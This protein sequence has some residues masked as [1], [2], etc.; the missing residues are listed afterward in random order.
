MREGDTVDSVFESRS[1]LHRVV[2]TAESPQVE[3]VWGVSMI[4]TLLT[5]FRQ[6]HLRAWTEWPPLQ[7]LGRCCKFLAPGLL[8]I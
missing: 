4:S 8:E 7:D 5:S 3:Y 2:D 6:N 1:K